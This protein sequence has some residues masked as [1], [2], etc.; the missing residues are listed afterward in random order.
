MKTSL[1]GTFF[2]T[3]PAQKGN[4]LLRTYHVRYGPPLISP[5]FPFEATRYLGRGR[6]KGGK[7]PRPDCLVVVVVCACVLPRYKRGKRREGRLLSPRRRRTDRQIRMEKRG[8]E[9]SDGEEGGRRRKERRFK[10]VES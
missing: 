3:S 7:I 9:R 6:G 2:P 10:N 8:K 4:I 1:N 5:P